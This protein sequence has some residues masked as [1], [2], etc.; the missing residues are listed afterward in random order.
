MTEPPLQVR[1]LRRRFDVSQPWLNRVIERE[2]QQFLTAVADVTFDIGKGETFA[3]VGESGS[4]KSTIARMIVGLLAVTEGRIRF[5]DKDMT[6]MDPAALRSLCRR[7]QMIFQ[8]PFAS[9]N[10]CWRVGDII[11]EPMRTFGLATG[12]EAA[13]EVARFQDVVGLSARDNKQFPHEFSGG[14]RQRIAIARALSS[15]PEFI[16]CDEPTSALDMS[17]QAKILNQMRDLQDEFGVTYLFISHDPSVANHREPYGDADRRPV[18]GPSGGS[19]QGLRG[20]RASGAGLKLRFGP[21]S[22]AADHL[23]RGPSRAFSGENRET[24]DED[25][26]QRNEPLARAGILFPQGAADRPAGT[27]RTL[28]RSAGRGTCRRA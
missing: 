27:A 8:H 23:T 20:G 11:A 6:A 9:L 22:V 17:V 26:S 1:K 12:P 10:P 13:V 19:N 3:L 25:F 24:P 14:Q 18:S 4:G 5:E 21:G 16:V 2:T 28:S 15:K 7:F